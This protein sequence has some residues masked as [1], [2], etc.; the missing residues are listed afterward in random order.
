[1]SH[2]PKKAEERI[3]AG[4]KKY[5]GILKEV[6][7]R[8]IN[9]SDTVTII[10][11]ML[12]DIFGYDKYQEI[13]SEFAIRNTYCDLAIKQNGEVVYLIECKAIGV[14]LKEE[15]LRQAIEYSATKGIDWAI[16][17]NGHI[18]KVYKVI[19]GKPVRAEEVFCIDFIDISL[20]DAELIEKVFILSKE[21]ISKSVIESF[22]EQS[23]LVNKFTISAIL[24]SDDAANFIRKNLRA[25]SKQTK[26]D[27]E[28]IKNILV[29]EIIKRDVTD[30]EELKTASKKVR[31]LMKKANSKK[32]P[33]KSISGM[34]GDGDGDM[35]Q[36]EEETDRFESDMVAETG[37]SEG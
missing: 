16:L 17:T 9:E 37:D 27:T 30:S 21:A 29:D 24:L 11:D 8:D 25:L 32:T 15:H 7:S 6:K 13:T 26:V 28:T 12:S 3:K 14:D 18:W 4:I 10:A 5:S 19:Y 34:S 23:K 1:V 36:E 31:R 2:I 33:S 20:R 35:A 22:H